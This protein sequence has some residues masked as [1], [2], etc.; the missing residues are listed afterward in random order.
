MLG[1]F[2]EKELSRK[3]KKEKKGPETNHWCLFFFCASVPFA[4]QIDKAPVDFCYVDLL[5]LLLSGESEAL[6]DAVNTDTTKLTPI[7]LS[8]CLSFSFYSSF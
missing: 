5:L 7:F 1:C 2:E 3:G 6:A 8:L 4:S